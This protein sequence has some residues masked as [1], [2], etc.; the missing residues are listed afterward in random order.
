MPHSRRSVRILLTA[1]EAYPALERAFLAAQTEIWASFMVFD[2]QTRLRSP[3]ALAIGKTWF[4]LIVHVLNKGVAL[5]VVISDVD[6][7]ARAEMHR[8]ATRHLRLFSAAAAVANPGAKLKILRPCHP[9]ETGALVRLCIW[10]Y[11]MKK[12][13]RLSGWLNNLAPDHRAAALRDM[14]GAV[15]NLRLRKDG[16]VGIRLWSLPRLFP[17]VHHQKLA[18]IDRRL[19]YIGGLDLNERRYDTPNHRR[20]GDQTWHDVQLMIEGPVVAEAQDHLETFQDV[21]EGRKQPTKTRRLLRTL[22]LPS[23]HSLWNF[24]PKPFISELQTAHRI[25]A[26]RSRQLIYMESQYFRDVRLARVL[27]EAARRS[28]GLNLILILPAAPD[29]VAFEGKKA[30]DARY[31]EAMQARSL[32]IIRKAFGSRLFVGSPAQPRPALPDGKDDANGRS[33]LHGAPLVYVHSKVSVFDQDAAIVSSANLNGRSLR[34]DTEAGVY[35]SAKNDVIELR[36]RTMAHWLPADIGPDA[37]EDATA[38]KVWAQL[39]WQNAG[40]PPSQRRGFLLPHDF[41]AA[42]AFGRELPILPPEFV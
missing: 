38:A 40:K 9:A 19:L 18:V 3:E 1:S 5:N 36:Y 21:I 22:S 30:L 31:G 11:V 24:G 35:L 25:L 34:W 39:A 7:I 37:F 27:A 14:D 6:P 23:R 41:A 16:T 10:P 42:E 12:L 33:T 2:L 20:A 4:D 32:R 29:D 8:A 28:P 13:F 26:Q 17:V 15:R